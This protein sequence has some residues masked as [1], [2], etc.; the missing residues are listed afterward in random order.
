MALRLSGGGRAE[1][2]FVAERVYLRAPRLSDWSAWAELRHTSRDF[3]TSWEPAWAPDAL[4]R[5]SYRRRLRRLAKDESEDIGY[6]YFIFRRSD[7]AVLGGITLSNLQRGAAQSAT[8][9]YWIGRRH[10]GQGYM[11]EALGVL[12]AHAFGPLALHRL[13]AACMPENARSQRLL[14]RCGFRQEGHAR[15]YLRINGVWHDHLLFALLATEYPAAAERLQQ[16]LGSGVSSGG[17]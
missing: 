16:W 12:L 2:M 9:G 17:R 10:A 11:A 8:I 5:A 13:E 6:A 7:E 15:Q 14:E 4:A 1:P 3:L